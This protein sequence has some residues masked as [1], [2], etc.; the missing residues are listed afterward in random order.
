M[1]GGLAKQNGYYTE[2]QGRIALNQKTF[3]NSATAQA[4]T[5]TCAKATPA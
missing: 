5:S 4:K 1:E 2:V 3:S